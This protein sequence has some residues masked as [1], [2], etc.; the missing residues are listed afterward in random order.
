MGGLSS[1]QAG[2]IIMFKFFEKFNNAHPDTIWDHDWFID[3][4]VGYLE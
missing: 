1:V 4:P 3:E 2:N